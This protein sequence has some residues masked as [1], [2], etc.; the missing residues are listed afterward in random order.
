LL[1]F[2]KEKDVKFLRFQNMWLVK[3]SPLT[4]QS[5]T[6]EESFLLSLASKM[7][8][9]FNLGPKPVMIG[10]DYEHQTHESC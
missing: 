10:K 6:Y 2:S 8:P 4:A 7:T 9:N 3:P 5:H 1:K